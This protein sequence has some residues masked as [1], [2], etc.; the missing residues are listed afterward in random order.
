M[1]KG[2][3]PATLF[4][5][6]PT[7][8]TNTWGQAYAPVNY[9][10]RFHGPML[11]REALARSMNIPAVQ[12]MARVG[13]PDFLALTARVGID[14]PPNDQYGL[15]LTLG[16]GETR[17]LDLTAGYAALANGGRRVAPTP[18]RR[19]ELA[20]GQLLRDYLQS[21]VDSRQPAVVSPQ[22]AYLITSVLSDNEAR[23][24]SFGASSVL[25]LS[26]PAAVKTGTTTDFRDNLTVG[27]TPDLVVGVW[28]GN[29]DNSPMRDVSGITGAAPIWAEVMEKALEGRPPQPFARPDGIVEAEI[30]LDG[31]RAP[32]PSCPPD[33]R[34]MEVF[35][36]GQLPLPPD[37]VVERA[38]REGNP[39]LLNAPPP[40]PG[41]VAVTQPADGTLVSRGLLSVRGT[42]NP[43]G[44]QSYQVE[45]GVGDNPERWE[46][47][48]GPHLSPVADEQ[49]TQWG[50]E[51][52]PAG[53]YALRVTAFTD[54]GPLTAI[55]RF[56]L[57]P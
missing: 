22:H 56:D 45:Y 23:A 34:R 21:T 4:W 57:A 46:W 44:F 10:E 28:V 17:L 36:A 2:D 32:S 5:D 52:L 54:G 41:G 42:V 31:G 33:R 14:F 9:D 24:K 13:V 37:E 15:A 3:T 49:L 48:S 12:A 7:T 53:R 6:V 43:P 25:K 55:T 30:C 40:Q 50:T 35:K 39:D 19:V 8:F 18:I 20:D 11:L 26:R 51:G 27:Y 29:A 38:A 16:G 47:I 1:E